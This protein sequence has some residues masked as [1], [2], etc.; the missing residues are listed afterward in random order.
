MPN[1]EYDL[2]IVGAG[3]A[4]LMAARTA[5]LKGLR[6]GVIESGPVAGRKIRIAGGGLGN[7]TN[8]HMSPEHYTGTDPAFTRHVLRAFPPA[9]ILQLLDECS[10]PYEEREHGQIFGLVPAVR[11]VEVLMEQARERGA[12]FFFRHEALSLQRN[13]HGFTVRCATPEGDSELSSQALL[14]ATGSPAW[15]ESGATDAGP[16]LVNSLGLTGSETHSAEPFRPVLSPLIMPPEWPFAGLQGLSA[17]VRLS[18]GSGKTARSFTLPLLFTHKGLSGPAALQISCHWRPGMAVSIDFLPDQSLKTLMHAPEN[19][20]V[21]VSTLLRKHLPQRLAD[22]LFA[23]TL[24]LLA[25]ASLA[26]PATE[27]GAAQW[28]RAQRDILLTVVHTHTATPSRTEGM[29]HAEAAAGG[30]RTAHINPKTLESKLVPGLYFAGEI[31]DIAGALGGYNLHWAFST[32]I[33][34]GAREGNLL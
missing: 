21:P 8:L 16:R 31:L 9:A 18:V 14:L 4:G 6:V 2:L 20:S 17:P 29:L 32:G 10:I 26:S 7:F 13:A 19:G 5:S 1:T 30:I 23:H 22:T 33:R 27:R 12:V 34:A 15:A 11:L 3:A 28:S 24:K 25:R